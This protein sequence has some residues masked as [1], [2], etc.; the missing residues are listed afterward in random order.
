MGAYYLVDPLFL[1]SARKTSCGG[2]EDS[3]GDE[4]VLNL[5]LH[6]PKNKLF[7][8]TFLIKII[9][10]AKV[11]AAI[12]G[13]IFLWHFCVTY[14]FKKKKLLFIMKRFLRVFFW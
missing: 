7:F 1:A 6:H 14:V 8:V 13:Y 11:K 12:I 2:G 4:F 5:D 9:L 10:I 3:A